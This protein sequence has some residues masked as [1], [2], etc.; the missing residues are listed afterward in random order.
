[1]PGAVAHSVAGYQLGND[2]VKPQLRDM[3]RYKPDAH[4]ASRPM[5]TGERSSPIV[6]IEPSVHISAAARRNTRCNPNDALERGVLWDLPRSADVYNRRSGQ[7][8][9][10]VLARKR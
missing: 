9:I 8:S 4:H 5:R 2:G 3:V 10:A 7:N 1:V 6:P